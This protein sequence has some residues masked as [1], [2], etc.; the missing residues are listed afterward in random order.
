MLVLFLYGSMMWGIF[1]LMPGISWEAHL[2][3]AIAGVLVAYNYRK[4]GPQ[5]RLYKWEVEDDG[6]DFEA[7]EKK[8]EEEQ[9]RQ[10]EEYR[11]FL[12]QNNFNVTYHFKA[13]DEERNDEL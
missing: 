4:E 8:L 10:Q 6:V 1:P 13:K 11:K 9:L 12:E 3:G 2:F 5:R 7:E